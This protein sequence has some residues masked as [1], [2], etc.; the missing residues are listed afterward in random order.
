MRRYKHRRKNKQRKIIIITSI[1]LL[2]IMTIGYATFSTNLNIT[3]KGN[4]LE[5]SRVIQSW[6]GNSNEDFHTDYY[7]KNIVSVTFLDTGEVP[8]NATE[9][10]NVSENKNKGGVMAW[11]IPNNEDNTKYDLYIGASGGV[12]AN[13]D[14]GY[15]FYR[16]SSLKNIDFD[17]NFDTSNVTDMHAMFNYCIELSALNL[18]TFDTQNVTNMSYMF[19]SGDITKPMKLETIM[20]GENF[21]T[22]NVVNM[23]GMFGN[24]SKLKELNLSNFNT[25]N[26]TNMHDMFASCH[27]LTFLD[28]TNWNTSKVTDMAGMFYAC[29]SLVSLDLCHFDTTNVKNM[30]SMFADSFNFEIIRVSSNWTI[31]NANTTNMFL[32]SGVSEVTTGQC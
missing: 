32:N 8:D 14:S 20:F 23:A 28:L 13:E 1:C 11:V 4:I 12:I 9:S 3:A 30:R 6:N 22:N 26:V 24:C 10:W 31:K 16:F 15:L 2:L 21:K 18:T 27:S 7:R 25:S 17:N 19:D 29:R 5:K